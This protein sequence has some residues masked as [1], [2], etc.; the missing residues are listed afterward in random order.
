MNNSHPIYGPGQLS[1]RRRRFFDDFPEMR[2]AAKPPMGFAGW[3][4]FVSHQTPSP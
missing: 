3:L 4:L 2:I 1:R